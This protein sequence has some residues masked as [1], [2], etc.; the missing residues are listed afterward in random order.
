VV[1]AKTPAA[2]AGILE[3]VFC[4]WGV[5]ARCA[6]QTVFD[7]APNVRKLSCREVNSFSIAD[8]LPIILEEFFAVSEDVQIGEVEMV[9]EWR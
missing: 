8:W 9:L 1:L 3:S 4:V 7:V 2:K 6:V 5:G